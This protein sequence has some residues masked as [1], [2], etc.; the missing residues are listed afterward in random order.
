MAFVIDTIEEV[1]GRYLVEAETEEEARE[2]FERGDVNEP[3]LYEAL[4]AEIEKVELA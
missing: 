4:S 2:K 3:T 1:H